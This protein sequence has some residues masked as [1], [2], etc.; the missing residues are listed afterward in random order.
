[1][2]HNCLFLR[3]SLSLGEFVVLPFA[4]R[5]RTCKA[6]IKKNIS[7]YHTYSGINDYILTVKSFN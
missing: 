6:F 5:A 4:T 1:M 2:V 7:H 3:V